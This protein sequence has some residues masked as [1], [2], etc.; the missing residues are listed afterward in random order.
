MM[1][2]VSNHR[3]HCTS[4]IIYISLITPIIDL[5]PSPPIESSRPFAAP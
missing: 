3:Q 1:E 2:H 4:L 5:L